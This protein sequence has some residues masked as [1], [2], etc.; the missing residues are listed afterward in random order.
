MI[1]EKMYKAKNESNNFIDESFNM[2]IQI[3]YIIFYNI[4]NIQYPF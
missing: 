1:V 2:S 4:F 3:H